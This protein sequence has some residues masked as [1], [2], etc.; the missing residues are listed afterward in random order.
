V[1]RLSRNELADRAGVASGWIDRLVRLDILEPSADGTFSRGDVYRAR[2]LDDLQR[3]GIPIESMAKV[4]AQGEVSLSTFDL[5]VYERFTLVS[6]TTFREASERHHVP[7][8]LLTAVRESIG[9]SEPDPDDLLREDELR[10]LPLIEFQ[11]SKGF[12]HAVIERWLRVYGESLGRITETETEWWRTEVQMP[13]LETGV[14]VAEMLE[15]TNRFGGEMNELTEQAL[16]AVYRAQQEHAWHENFIED[17]ESELERAGL[18]ARSDLPPALCFLDLTGYTRLTEERGDEAAAEMAARLSGLVRQR[19]ERH[20]GKVVRWLGDG[21][22]FFFREPAPAVTA[23]LGMMDDVAGEGLP[24]THV[25]VSA[26]PVV[27]R[28]GDYFG[29]TVNLASRIADY[30]RPG[31][32]LVSQEVVDAVELPEVE[33]TAIGPVELKGFSVPQ[34]L[35]AARR[36][37]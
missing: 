36:R 13:E 24:S 6:Q 31:E 3:A 2:L 22:M 33:F 11:L 5:P 10:I 20:L 23:A 1:T 28:G 14:S 7:L 16:I 17:V 30:A 18:R 34:R 35:H 8:E 29:R 32:L 9:S 26:G 21:V 19:A 25:G 37:A 4:L 27:I 15:V 12:R